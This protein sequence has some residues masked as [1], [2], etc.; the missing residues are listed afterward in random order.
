MNKY[1]LFVFL[2]LII[3][4]KNYSQTDSSAKLITKFK[5]GVGFFHQSKWSINELNR[6]LNTTEISNFLPYAK[7]SYY[8][9]YKKYIGSVSVASGGTYNKNQ[10]TLINFSANAGHQ[11]FRIDDLHFYLTLNYSYSLFRYI[12]NYLDKGVNISIN[13]TSN[14]NG[15]SLILSNRASLTGISFLFVEY[16]KKKKISTL[17]ELSYL[18]GIGGNR[19]GSDVYTIQYKPL[20]ENFSVIVLSVGF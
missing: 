20:K 13:N 3:N 8:L 1:L 14:L 5:P 18:F 10:F 9:S 11:I 15:G 16:S 19:W 2:F 7:L 17:I 12:V 4:V 6:D